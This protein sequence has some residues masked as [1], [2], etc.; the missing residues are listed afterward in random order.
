M[1]KLYT[2]TILVFALAALTLVLLNLPAGKKPISLEQ[3]QTMMQEPAGY[4][5]QSAEGVNFD[6]V[7][8][9]AA[10]V[11]P[12]AVLEEAILTQLEGYENCDMEPVNSVRYFYNTVD[13]NNDNIAETIVH[14]VGG[15]T[16]GT[17]GC[18]TLVFRSD[19]TRLELISHLTL[20]NNP[21]LVSHQTTNGWRDLVLYVSGGGAKTSYHRL[22]FTGNSY[23][24]NPSV[25]PVLERDAVI[26][27]DAYIANKILFDTPAPILRSPACGKQ[28][29]AQGLMHSE[30]LGALR[31]DMPEG[32]VVVLLGEP[33]E[34]GDKHLSEA[35]ALYHQGWR[36]PQQ[37]IF[38]ELVSESTSG[39]QRVASIRA[40]L[41]SILET[42]KGI[43]VGDSFA[44]VNKAYGDQLNTDNSDPPFT[45][46]AGSL[47]D[48]VLFSFE[49]GKIIQIFLGATAE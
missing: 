45:L 16:C 46:L 4:R 32:E 17:G 25:E 14:L 31:I 42:T 12:D 24:D 27:G 20:T 21:I 13:L 39:K 19:G 10:D 8:Y 36:Y 9:T 18:T 6:D 37:G 30:S 29:P 35:D 3:I 7:S 1:K 2:W 5:L 38:L 11:V 49:E 28:E 15:F 48:G 34:K 33:D 41:H 44:A 22:R 40:G 26:K 23:P 47:Y 43:K